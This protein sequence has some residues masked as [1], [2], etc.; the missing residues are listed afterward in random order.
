M[1]RGREQTEPGGPSLPPLPL[2]VDEVS[3]LARRAKGQVQ[4][5]QTLLLH[6]PGAWA[7]LELALQTLDELLLLCELVDLTAE[8]V[9]SMRADA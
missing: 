1:T 5:T 6:T 4:G 7:R 9:V 3:T 8:G 2:T